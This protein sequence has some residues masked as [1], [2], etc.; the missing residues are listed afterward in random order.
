MRGDWIT[1]IAVQYDIIFTYPFDPFLYEFQQIYT[2]KALLEQYQ[3]TKITAQFF[4]E[5]IIKY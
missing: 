1:V 2:F 4:T 3:E 5:I